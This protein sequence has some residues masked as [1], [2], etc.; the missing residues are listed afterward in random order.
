MVRSSAAVL[1]VPLSVKLRLGVVEDELLAP[2]LLRR[3][4]SWGA[5]TVAWATIH[6][7]TRN[8]RYTRLADWNL[9][10]GACAMAAGAPLRGTVGLVPWLRRGHLVRELQVR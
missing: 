5:G 3:M 9:V 4:R 7:R 10:R 6:G 8:Q 1:S 2:A